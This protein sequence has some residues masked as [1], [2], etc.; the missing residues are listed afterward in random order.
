MSVRV[1][2]ACCQWLQYGLASSV[3]SLF[4]LICFPWTS[5]YTDTVRYQVNEWTDLKADNNTGAVQFVFIDQDIQHM[6][7]WYNG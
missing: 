2:Q 4:C 7:T 3:L 1:I 5:I 6:A